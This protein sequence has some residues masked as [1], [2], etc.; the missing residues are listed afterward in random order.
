MK[1]WAKL[2]LQFLSILLKIRARQLQGKV[3]EG[4]DFLPV[5]RWWRIHETN[6][7]SFMLINRRPLR[8][9]E[10]VILAQRF[11]KVFEEFIERFGF[12]EQ[13]LLLM[14]K[15]RHI[16]RLKVKKIVTG[17]QSLNTMIEIEKEKIRLLEQEMKAEHQESLEMKANVE[18]ICGYQI[19]SHRMSTS[20]FYSLLKT[21]RNVRK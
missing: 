3:Y 6:D 7:V 11:E 21:L 5:F 14:A 4:V 9:G 8:M 20:E 16:A 2:N 19:D 10:S 12:S 1:V 13:T 17:D 15:R 18:M